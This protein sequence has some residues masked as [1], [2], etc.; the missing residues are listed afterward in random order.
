MYALSP[1]SLAPSSTSLALSRIGTPVPLRLAP[2]AYRSAFC[3]PW[4]LIFLL[5]PTTTPLLDVLVRPLW[6]PPTT[7]IVAR[8]LA[9][10][11]A[12]IRRGSSVCARS[13]QTVAFCFRISATY[14][15]GCVERPLEDL[16]R[17]PLAVLFVRA[18]TMPAPLLLLVEVVEAVALESV[19]RV[20]ELYCEG[21]GWYA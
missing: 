12:A 10:R 15:V 20:V 19:R 3:A 18:G 8:I 4:C 21:A 16:R 2:G 1:S 7:S 17:P 11:W 13:H 14:D 6:C 9:A 5:T